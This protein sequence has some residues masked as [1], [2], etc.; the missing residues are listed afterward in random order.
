MADALLRTDNESLIHYDSAGTI[1]RLSVPT[2]DHYLP[3]LYPAAMR[4]GN[5]E[6]TF[7]YTG[8]EMA[9]MSMRCVRFGMSAPS[10]GKAVGA[11]RVKRG[12][13]SQRYGPW[14]LVAG[15]SE[16]IGASYARGL[17]RRGL[18][19]VLVARRREPLERFADGVRAEFGVETRCVEGDLGDLGFLQALQSHCSE[20]DLGLLIYNAAHS[21]I[22]EFT[23]L[24]LD[25][26]LKVVDVN[27]RGPVALLSGML[28]G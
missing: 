16:G 23:N 12:S 5:D 25:D 3:L 17:A 8:I 20:L 28:P 4:D 7:P 27:V 21:P 26:V 10:A 11:S 22:G 18:N 9:S 6:V 14:A 13:F 24:P 19:L 1:A 2:N 15:A